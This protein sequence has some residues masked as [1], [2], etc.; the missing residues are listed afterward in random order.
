M[1]DMSPCHLQAFC[2]NS[3]LQNPVL[4][5]GKD[6]FYPR[7]FGCMASLVLILYDLIYVVSALSLSVPRCQ[8]ICSA[9]ILVES[10]LSAGVESTDPIEASKRLHC[11][12][13]QQWGCA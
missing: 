10:L 5:L 11:S 4:I 8:C 1:I 3:N 6:V 12:K 7:H 9:M 2:L 13:V